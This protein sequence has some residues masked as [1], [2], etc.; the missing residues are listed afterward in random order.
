MKGGRKPALVRSK[1]PRSPKSPTCGRCFR[2]SHKTEDCRHQI[3][4]LRC[5]CVGHMAAHCPVEPHRS[6]KHKKVHVR[7]KWKNTPGS[8]LAISEPLNVDGQ[9]A[10]QRDHSHKRTSLSLPLTSESAELRK[11]LAKVAVVG[12]VE[13]F[14]NEN[15]ILEVVPSIINRKIAEPVTPINDCNFLILLD[16]RAEVK[17]VVKLGTCKVSTKDGPC[18][19]ISACVI[20]PRSVIILH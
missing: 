6:P 7:S 4:C 10:E 15:S 12:L 11:K 14:V 2:S 1:R 19:L 5:A 17:K 13:G 8:S 9:A 18:V 16:S 20:V 3:V